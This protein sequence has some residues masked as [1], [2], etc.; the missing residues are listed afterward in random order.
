MFYIFYIRST[1]VNTGNYEQY[2]H[3]RQRLHSLHNA[4]AL[5]AFSSPDF[6]FSPTRS[7]AKAAVEPRSK[8]KRA[9]A[10]VE[11]AFCS[12]GNG[13]LRRLIGGNGQ[14]KRTSSAFDDM[15]SGE[16]PQYKN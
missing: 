10:R 9:A 15:G 4:R 2:F 7:T 6:S 14:V 13:D 11:H 8:G 16:S 12:G 3:L 5:L 1:Y